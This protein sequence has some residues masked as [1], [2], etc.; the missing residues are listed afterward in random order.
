MVEEI[1]LLQ[2]ICSGGGSSSLETWELGSAL[3]CG[4]EWINAPHCCSPAHLAK[5]ANSPSGRDV[6][7]FIHQ[8]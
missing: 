1:R 8:I 7:I 5:N 4:L 6:L 3:L 2:Q